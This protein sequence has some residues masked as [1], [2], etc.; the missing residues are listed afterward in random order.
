MDPTL[1]TLRLH[2]FNNFDS[3][4]HVCNESD[5]PR[6]PAQVW[7]LEMRCIE[8]IQGFIYIEKPSPAIT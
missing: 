4:R 8:C 3:S 5:G 1:Q 7:H 6:R 2:R